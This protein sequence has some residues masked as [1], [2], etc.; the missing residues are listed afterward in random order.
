MRLYIELKANDKCRARFV[1]AR[2]LTCYNAADLRIP[3][4]SVRDYLL[5]I[6]RA[7]RD[8]IARVARDRG[9]LAAIIL[10]LLPWWS[11]VFIRKN[12]DWLEALG[13]VAL[14]IFMYWWM[15]RSGSA[16]APQVK[17]PHLELLLTF[18]MIALWVEYRAIMCGKLL[19]I[20]PADFNCFNNLEFEI[21]PKLALS[22]AIPIGVL[23]FAGYRARDL[24]VNW[25]WR[26]WWVGL[27]PLVV[28]VSARLVM[29]NKNPL[30]VVETS[31]DQ[32][33]FHFFGAGLPEEILFRAILLTRL[34]AWLKNPGWALFAAALI[35]G[36]AH[37]P[38]D[39]LVFTRRDWRETWITLLTFQVGFGAAFG[40]AYQRI[41]NVYPIAILHML[42]NVI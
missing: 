42:V 9:A 13:G 30:T 29:Q 11:L 12:P 41:R 1:E 4:F 19:P 27:F 21:V 22:V 31:R 36:L 37:L 33:V 5:A 10:L 16:P 38:I 32:F 40:F 39:Y 15:S 24:G 34:E 8:S 6:P 20:I 7:G 3:K 35:F 23:F 18:A 17:H 26:A 28:F 14:I 25:N 2:A